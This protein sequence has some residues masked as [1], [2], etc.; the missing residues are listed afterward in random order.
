M[1]LSVFNKKDR[2]SAVVLVL[3]GILCECKR[4]YVV[5]IIIVIVELGLLAHL[6]RASVTILAQSSATSGIFSLC[7]SKSCF[8]QCWCD[9][10]GIIGLHCLGQ[11]GHTQSMAI[12]NTLQSQLVSI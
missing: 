1:V 8:V 5:V 9:C 12:Q 7:A 11:I 2:K 6:E 4:E 3:I 10:W